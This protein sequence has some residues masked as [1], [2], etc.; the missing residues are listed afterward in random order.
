MLF[1]NPQWS[2]VKSSY[3]ILIANEPKF[4]YNEKRSLS[5]GESFYNNPDT[6]SDIFKKVLN[7]IAE[8]IYTQGASWFASPIRTVYFLK[9]LQNIFMEI[10]VNNYGNTYLLT[11]VPHSLEIFPSY[12]ELRWKVSIE[13]HNETLPI[14]SIEY[15]DEFDH[16]PKGGL[17]I[18]KPNPADEELQVVETDNISFKEIELSRA[19]VKKK[20]REARLKAT[21]LALKAER[22]AEKYFR[23]YGNTANFEYESDLSLD[24]GEEESEDE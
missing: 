9:K 1:S 7:T 14:N 24:S 4:A 11:W 16:Q 6:D 3:T 2:S 21:I 8:Q 18:I 22:M 12:F 23:R 5:S 13:Q 20:I 10:P 15:S 19:I 17:L